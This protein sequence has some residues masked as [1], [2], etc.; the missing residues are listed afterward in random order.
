[1]SLEDVRALTFDTG[2]TILDWQSGFSKA[3]ERAGAKYGLEKDWRALANDLRRR[4]LGRMANL[5]E[6]SPP[7]YNIDDSHRFVLDEIISENGLDA[8]TKEDRYD[9]W[10]RTSHDLQ[11]W[12]DF[13]EILPKLRTKFICA[14]FTILSFRLIIDTAKRN[15]L[16]WDVVISCEAIGKY[17]RLPEAYLTAA[18]WLQLRPEECCM[19]AC[20][21]S[22]LDAAKNAGFKTAFVRRPDEWGPAGPPDPNPNPHHDIIADDFPDLARQLGIDI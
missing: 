16:S 4:T 10:W 12:S 9:I 21:N 17:K 6:Y 2:G 5:G 20:H 19:V 15:G 3:L 13:P 7:E 22:D 11:A 18:S 14:S 1:M 8:F